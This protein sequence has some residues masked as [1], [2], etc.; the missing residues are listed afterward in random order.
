MA[1]TLPPLQ[2]ADDLRCA[3]Q[4]VELG[5]DPVKQLLLIVTL[6]VSIVNFGS[7]R[8]NLL[9]GFVHLVLFAGYVIVIFD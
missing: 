8:T 1:D 9:Q 6:A 3:P 7:G 4:A 5:L 2:I